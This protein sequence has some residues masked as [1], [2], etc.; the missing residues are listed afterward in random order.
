MTDPIARLF[1][2]HEA[3]RQAAAQLEQA[4]IPRGQVSLAEQ[5]R[6]GSGGTLLTVAAGE[7]AALAARLLPGAPAQIDA[8]P[9]A[10]M[11]GLT[12]ALT[13]A[14]PAYVAGGTANLG[15]PGPD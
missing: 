11:P 13:D 15:T 14:A 6:D 9:V 5:H 1:P 8:A 3:A 12:A 7:H 2:N 10:E 4:G